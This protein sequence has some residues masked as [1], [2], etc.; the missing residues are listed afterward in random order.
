MT[1]W[2]SLPTQ[3]ENHGLTP[4]LYTHLQAADVSIPIPIKKQLYAGVIQRN[5][6]N[7]V[8]LKVLAEILTA[9]QAVGIDALILKGAALARL[10]YPEPGLRSMRDVDCAGQ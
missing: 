6:A 2:N 9:F 1:D 4:L 8:R 3:A 5:H 10:V 7:R